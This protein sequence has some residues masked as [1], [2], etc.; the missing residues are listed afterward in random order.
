MNSAPNFGTFPQ[1]GT[2]IF[3]F[4]GL[5]NVIGLA[6]ILTIILLKFAPN[7]GTFPSLALNIFIYGLPNVIWV[8]LIADLV[9]SHANK[10]TPL[11]CE[12]H[13]NGSIGL[14]NYL[15]P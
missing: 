14:F 15:N 9:T 10:M 2:R 4:Y 12:I 8:S 11:F 7:F 1:F 6:Q 5:P 3:F 13:E